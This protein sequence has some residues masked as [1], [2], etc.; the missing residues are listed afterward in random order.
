MLIVCC[1]AG[2]AGC[3]PGFDPYDGARAWRFE[4]QR[5]RGVINFEEGRGGKLPDR[6][7]RMYHD[8]SVTVPAC[9]AGSTNDSRTGVMLAWSGGYSNCP[10]PT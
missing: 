7:K 8:L 10:E 5:D 9:S 3:L 2:K 1:A 6:G 4:W